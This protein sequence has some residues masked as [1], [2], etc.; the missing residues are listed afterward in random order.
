MLEDHAREEETLGEEV[1]TSNVEEPTEKI[2]FKVSPTF[3]KLLGVPELYARG[4]SPTQYTHNTHSNT[5]NIPRCLV[6]NSCSSCRDFASC[7]AV[8]FSFVEAAKGLFSPL[9]PVGAFDT[10]IKRRRG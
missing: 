2:E 5:P 6:L 4:A 7:K 1:D 10:I 3:F 8:S 9:V